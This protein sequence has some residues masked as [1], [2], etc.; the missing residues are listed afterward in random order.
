MRIALAL[1]L[2]R[3][4]GA[5]QLMREADM[6]GVQKALLEAFELHDPARI[7][8]AID[9][10]ASA[11]VPIK[12]KM[13]VD[14]LLEMYARSDHFPDCLRTL[15]AA[16]AEWPDPLVRAV[17]L[18]DAAELGVR[19]TADPGRVHRHVSLVS[20]FTPLLDATLLHVAAE[21]GHLEAA[22]TLI[23]KG[24]DVNA[25]AGF[26]AQGL[27][28]HTPIFHVVNSNANRGVNVMR[29]LIAAGADCTLRVD[30]LVWGRGFD[31]ETVCLDVTP[32]SY[33]QLGLLPQMHRAETAIT[34]NIRDLLTAAGRTVPDFRNVPNRYL[35]QDLP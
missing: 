18:N 23:A 21:Y 3:R 27:G 9:A 13:P 19:L 14:W 30:G 29:S 15:F 8:A 33:A 1:R 12:G 24:A 4:V 17:L 26:D 22:K 28:G 10:G 25:R 11:V 35:R 20:A 2:F 6:E 32:V 5:G 16:G 7:R 31:W 34:A